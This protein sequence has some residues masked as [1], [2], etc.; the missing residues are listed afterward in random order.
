[1]WKIYDLEEIIKRW[2]ADLRSC[3]CAKNQ[4]GIEFHERGV[5]AL[6]SALKTIK[7]PSNLENATDARCVCPLCNQPHDPKLISGDGPM[8]DWHR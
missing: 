5:T 4:Q 2:K 8:T 3:K 7:Q 6:E 1:M